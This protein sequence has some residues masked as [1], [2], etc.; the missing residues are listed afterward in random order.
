MA[1]KLLNDGCLNWV[2]EHMGVPY[3]P[4]PLLGTD[5]FVVATKTRKINTSRKMATKKVKVALAKMAPAKEISVVKVIRSKSRP[6][7]RGTSEIELTLLKPI[8]VS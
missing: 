8:G 7:P 2:L 1:V 4:C 3:A 5:A 6:R